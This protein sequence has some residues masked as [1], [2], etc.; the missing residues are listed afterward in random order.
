MIKYK[1]DVYQALKDKGYN[2]NIIKR[3]NLLPGQTLSNI[4]N[5]KSI[6]FE[7]LNKI[8]ILLR[9]QPGDII[10]CVIT[11]PEKIKYFR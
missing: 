4:K 5:G 3:D 6:T 8:C 11:D 10:E 1:I 9:C 7:T 2:T